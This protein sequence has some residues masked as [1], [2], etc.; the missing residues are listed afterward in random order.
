MR[1]GGEGTG[2]G[3]RCKEGEWR[4]GLATGKLGKEQAG[5]THKSS[6]SK[7]REKLRAMPAPRRT[8]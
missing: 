6:H 2:W 1:E 3:N 4:L 5:R 8:L 7:D